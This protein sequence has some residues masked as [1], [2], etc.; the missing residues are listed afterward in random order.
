M[1]PDGNIPSGKNLD[2]ML[3]ETRRLSFNKDEEQKA[4]KSKKNYQS[5][6]NDD[7]STSTQSSK[8]SFVT[9]DT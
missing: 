6:A 2:D 1:G 7:T 9:S 8:M 3:Q 5:V 4:K